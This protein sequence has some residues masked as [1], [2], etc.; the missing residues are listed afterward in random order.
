MQLEIYRRWKTGLSDNCQEAA[1]LFKTSEEGAGK[2][3]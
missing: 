2:G 3:D 1:C